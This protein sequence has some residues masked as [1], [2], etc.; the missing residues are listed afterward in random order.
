MPVQHSPLAKNT[1]S[2]RNPAGL[3]PTVRFPPNRTPSVDQLSVNLDR[4]RRMEGEAPSRRG[5][6]KSRRSR[7]FFGLLSGYPG[8]SDGARA[9][10]GEAED[11]DGEE[12]VEEEESEETEVATALEGVP[13]ASGASILAHSNQH[14]VSQAEPNFLNIM[15]QITQF[16]GQLTQA[17]APRDSSKAPAFK[18]PSMRAPDSFD[19]TQAHKLRGIIQS[20]QLVFHNHPANSSLTERKF[21]TQ[22]LF[23][24][25]ELANGFNPTSPIFPMKILP[26]SSII[27][28]YL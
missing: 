26:T 17:V 14:L 4:G 24:L 2:H 3:T 12:S 15:E 6:M 28:I 27:G 22:L 8:M 16:M 20:F 7:S 10:L 21:C 11:E 13:E 9:I 25:V 18:T 5:G 23:S 19:G 1:R